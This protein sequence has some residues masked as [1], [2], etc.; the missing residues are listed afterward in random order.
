M[1]ATRLLL[2]A[3]LLGA[4]VACTAVSP[5]ASDPADGAIRTSSYIGSG[6]STPTDTT[7]TQT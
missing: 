7:T 3:L 4:S 6:Q 1:N 5:T 2:A